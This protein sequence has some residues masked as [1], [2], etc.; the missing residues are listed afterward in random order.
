[1]RLRPPARPN[2]PA[3]LR[4]AAA[5][6]ASLVVP[7]L[8][9]LR[10][11]EA[12]EAPAGRGEGGL[13]LG[14]TTGDLSGA[15]AQQV[16]GTRPRTGLT[17]GGFLVRPMRGALA[18]RPELLYLQKGGLRDVTNAAGTVRGSLF[19]KLGYVE[20]PVLLQLQAPGGASIGRVRPFVHAGPVLGYQAS[21]I[22]E[23][24][25]PETQATTGSCRTQT[26]SGRD[27][28]VS[29]LVGGGLGFPVGPRTLALTVRYQAGLTNVF[30]REVATG[31]SRTRNLTV[32]A[33]LAF[34]R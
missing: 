7:A 28:E 33:S 23:L 14:L 32:L 8:A 19:Y 27:L 10:A 26:N 17:I 11:Q 3:A 30:D 21:C 15:V 1:M 34:P 31:S 29:G 18:V 25:A 20:V 4:L 24:R 9:P 5:C 6:V 22:V 13:L 12:D 16:T 2:R